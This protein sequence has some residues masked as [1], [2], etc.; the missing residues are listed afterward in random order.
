MI[1]EINIREYTYMW[2]YNYIQEQYIRTSSNISYN[3]YRYNICYTF[4]Y[5]LLLT[6]YIDV[7]LMA[8]TED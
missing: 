5:S 7:I 4:C 2:V 6:A 3:V 1:K 8:K